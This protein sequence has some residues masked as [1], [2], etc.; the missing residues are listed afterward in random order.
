MQESLSVA[1]LNTSGNNN[2]N[3]SSLSSKNKVPR[4]NLNL[5][6]HGIGSAGGSHEKKNSSR[7]VLAQSMENLPSS[8]RHNKKEIGNHTPLFSPTNQNGTSFVARG[9]FDSQL[10]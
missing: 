4:L 8:G 2:V 1:N 9:Q 3:N 5:S 7:H 10:Q 6:V